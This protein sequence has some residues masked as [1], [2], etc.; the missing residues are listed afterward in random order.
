MEWMGPMTEQMQRRLFFAAAAAVGIVMVA[1][2]IFRPGEQASAGVELNDPNAWIEHGRDGQLLQIN[3]VTGEVTARVEV[4]EPGDVI[5]AVPHGD[6]AVVLNQTSG[7][8][9]LVNGSSLDVTSTTPLE[10]TDGAMQR[11][12]EVFGSDEPSGNVVIIDDDRLITVDPQSRIVTAIFLD[13]P[14]QDVVQTLDGSVLALPSD[15]QTVQSLGAR[16]FD[17][18]I[19]LGAPVG[20][21]ADERSLVRAGGSIW[22][23]DPARLSMSEVGPGD[24]LGPLAC[25]TSAASGA[26]T[27]G[28]SDA[29]EALI[30][31]YNPVSALLGVSDPVRGTCSEIQLD[32]DSRFFGAPV[33]NEGLAYLPNW[34]DGRIEVIDIVGERA[35]ASLPFGT[36]GKAFELDVRG[37]IVWANEPLG[38]LAAV[39]NE[40]GL[41][42]IPKLA[43]IVAGAVE[44]DA[45]G[46]GN[47]LTGADIDGS[48]LR[49]I[50][51]SGE[52]VIASRSD[53]NGGSGSG[54]GSDS[55]DAVSLDAFEAAA[56]PEPEAIG[57]SIQGPREQDEQLTPE[58][59]ATLIANFG[60]STATAKVDE[61][62]RFTDFSS[63][64]P[65]SWTWD[66]GDGTGSIEPN[67]EKSWSTEGVYE[68]ELIV[69]NA[70]GDKSSLSTEV[71]I[72]AKTVLIPPTADF[73]FD[74]STLEE[75]ESV[76][77]ESIT[78]GEA[79]LLEWDFGDGATEI[80][81][82]VSH[83]YEIA[84]EYTVTLTA[85]NPAGSTLASTRISVLAGVDSPQA[86]I[87]SLPVNV[88]NGQFVTLRSASLN[89]PTRLSWDLGDGSR[90]SGR[91][92][93]HAWE[94]PGTYRIRLTVENSAGTDSTFVDIAVTKRIDPPISQFT[95]SATE[96]LVG[97]TVTFSDL[98]LNQPTRLIWG[99]GDDTTARGSTASKS[100]STPGTYRVTLRATND[101]GTNR[102]GVT[103]KVVEPV[104]PPVASFTASPTIVA[105]NQP[106]SF[107]GT[108]SNNPTS[109]S[110]DFGDTG[111]SAIPNTTHVYSREGT[112]LVR[113]TVR[114][115]G[116]RS[117]TEQVVTVKRPP[118]A[119]FRWVND[120]RRV[121]FTDTSWDDPQ[122]WSWNFGDGSTSTNRNPTHRFDSEGSFIVTLT[123]SNAAGS[124]APNKQT[125]AVGD[126]P[127]ADFSCMAQ[128]P[129]L[130]CD[131]GSSKNA[132][133]YRWSSA[134]AIANTTPNR[135][136]TTLTYG[137]KGRYRVTLEVANAAGVTDEK[138]I[139]GPRVTQGR[140]PRI[141]NVNVDNRQGDLVRLDADFDRD[142][143]TWE[144]SVEGAELVEGGNTSRPLFR[145]PRNGTYQGTVRASNEFG[146]DTDGFA[147]TMDTI[148]TTASFEWSVIAPGIVSFTNTSNARG[149]AKYEW[150]FAGSA[151]VLD[152]DPKGPTV[153]YPKTGGTFGVI[154]VAT[155]VNGTDIAR[156]N[157][158]VPGNE[159]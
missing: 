114:N 41:L 56:A 77:F 159:R 10:L 98:S 28:S 79:D 16:G 129:R 144:W 13:E 37:S 137:S 74:R 103:I 151:E 40:F 126:P 99:F 135:E 91:S 43:A 128:G 97:E 69:T 93:Q 92:V 119:N 65:T 66:F 104:D 52:E 17:D 25:M 145:V 1:L 24:S 83:Q 80:G 156:R 11:D 148:E 134:D 85:S 71:A 54:R 53:G 73:T 30:L 116:G 146:G 105:P 81:P 72:V 120:D 121:K 133:S 32:L 35:I 139:R 122:E 118:S 90:G 88:V 154:L 140:A 4:S 124:S 55:A 101:A 115:E 62:L 31:A 68:V 59:A 111:S 132:V 78:S 36:N 45:S 143:T 51:D 106:V 48:G 95:Q 22:F 127:V 26:I 76:S 15:A 20:N 149:D 63:G 89:E 117:T 3:G 136:T 58:F 29:D 84:G 8:V 142:P 82:S 125:V 57:I 138:T 19:Q 7:T 14:L 23:V 2:I 86:V 12:L 102:S 42:P 64:S 61:V 131:A 75:A 60:V 34:G 108:S 47:T 147:F 27:G 109:W 49:I 123:V 100:W 5:R 141:Q 107:H 50:G 112:Y 21:T 38:P 9:S 70:R 94:K 39:V 6:G 152:T 150:L 96:V 130:L 153:Q 18:V 67:T 113:L 33:A 87:G 157:I 44:I 155:D 158:D 46:D 110:W